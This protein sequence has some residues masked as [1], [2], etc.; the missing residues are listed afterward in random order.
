MEMLALLGQFFLGI[1]VLLLG[2]AALKFVTVY[3]EEK[4]M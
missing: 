4:K 3:S 2:V 1:G